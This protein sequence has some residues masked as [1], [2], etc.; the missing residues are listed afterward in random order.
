MNDISKIQGTPSATPEARKPYDKQA[1]T[2][3]SEVLNNVLTASANIQNETAQS[4]EKV[5]NMGVDNIKVEMAK[6]GDTMHR[7]MQ[8]R[9]NLLNAYKTINDNQ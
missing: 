4:I 1:S 6:A 7:I 9:E 5:P 3:F 8:A 2:A